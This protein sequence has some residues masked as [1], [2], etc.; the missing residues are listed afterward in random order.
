M[1]TLRHV[2]VVL[3]ELGETDCEF[4]GDGRLAQPVNALS[5]LSYVLIGIVI[6]IAVTVARPTR[7]R[8]GSLVYAGCLVA[9]GLG[10]VAFHGP[11]IS[12]SQIMHDLPILLTVLFMANHD[13]LILRPDS[14]RELVTFAGVALVAL[15]L[16]VAIPVVVAPLTIGVAAVVLIAEVVIYR[17]RLRPFNIE[18]QRRGSIALAVTAA[19]GGASWL[20]GRSSSPLCD[21]DSVLQL[22]GLWHMLSAV[23]FALWYWWAMTGDQQ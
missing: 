3:R 14:G 17:R 8:N 4:L 7:E 21:P 20:L 9:V 19:V 5:S 11:Q 18:R 2:G 1:A 12:G 22:H 16:A 6:V 13:R 15:G 23:V 10:S